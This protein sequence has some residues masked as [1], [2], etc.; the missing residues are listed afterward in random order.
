MAT[1]KQEAVEM[2]PGQAVL[3]CIRLEFEQ[4]PVTLCIHI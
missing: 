2:Y 3:L 4:E 1:V